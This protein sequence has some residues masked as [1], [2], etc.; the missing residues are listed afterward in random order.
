[1]AWLM[2]EKDI[3]PTG[4]GVVFI[5]VV[6]FAGEV[7]FGPK[8]FSRTRNLAEVKAEI[9]AGVEIPPSCKVQLLLDDNELCDTA[10]LMGSEFDEEL[11]RLTMAITPSK[12]S[13]L[14]RHSNSTIQKLLNESF[15]NGWENKCQDSVARPTTNEDDGVDE[16]ANSDEMKSPSVSEEAGAEVSS[17]NEDDGVDERADSDEMEKSGVSEEA[18]TEV[19]SKELDI[20]RS[21]NGVV[22]IE[23]VTFAGEVVFGPKEFSRTRNLAEVKAEITAGVEIP[24]SCKVQLLLDDNE[25]CDTATL[26][27][28]EFDEELVRLTMA[29]TPSKRSRLWRHS[30][31]TIQKL[32]NE[33]FPNGWEN[34][35]QDSVARPT[36]NEDDGVDERANSDEMKSPSVSEEAGAEVRA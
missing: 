8:E 20:L 33:S 22:S 6:T 34:K 15:P 31:S 14:W 16:R 10:T 24:P 27:G 5:E 26:M 11:V 29:I 18:G 13:R 1:M 32:L 7:V 21:G 17:E 4:S 3:P 25:L 35:C 36:T 28:S 12:R 19:S 23:V 2:V 30:N 9:T